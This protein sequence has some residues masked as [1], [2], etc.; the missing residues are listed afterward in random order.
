MSTESR[1]VRLGELA[2]TRSGDKGDGSNI[3]VVARDPAAFQWLR[4]RLTPEAVADH[5]RGLGVG[6][7]QRFELPNLLAF[8]FVIEHALGGGASRSLRLDSQGKALGTALLELR[9]EDP[10]PDGAHHTAIEETC[11]M[12]HSLVKTDV[13][14]P[15]T[16]LTLA[17]PAKRNALSRDL[18]SK[19]RDELDRI[20]K[21]PRIRSVVLTGEGKVFCSGMDLKEAA[22]DDASTEAQQAGVDAMH[23]FADLIRRLHT[24]PQ[25][26]I[27]A[28]NGDA[29]AGGAGLMT[30]CDVAVAVAKARIGYPEVLRGL[31]PVVVMHD[32]TSLIGGR[33]ARQLLLSG[34]PITA[35]VAH[36]WG[37]VNEIAPDD[38][39]LA[40]AVELGKRYARGAPGAQAAVKKLL[41]ET[42]GKPADLRGAAAVSAAMRGSEEAREGMRAFLEKR[43]PR[44]VS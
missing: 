16:I 37:L 34:E 26:V 11:A 6:R 31:A 33:R 36:A 5:L 29:L 38:G 18:I 12:T 4:D 40:A 25:P 2:H 17:R 20:A 43:P 28:V 19:L 3:G 1:F 44:W 42:A 21:T 13:D 35:E 22:A 27:A 41:V 32:L 30:A 39:C 14:G 9:L 15:V 7:V 8:N 24:L 10:K 23:S